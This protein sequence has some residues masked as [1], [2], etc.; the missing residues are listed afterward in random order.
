MILGLLCWLCSASASEPVVP[1]LP[2]CEVPFF[3][4]FDKV[5]VEYNWIPSRD[6]DRNGVWKVERTLVPRMSPDEFAVVTKTQSAFYGLGRRF[7]DWIQVKD[8]TL[9]LQYEVRAQTAFTCSGAYVKLFSYHKYRPH[10]LSNFTDYTIMFGPDRCADK[11]MVQFIYTHLHPVQHSYIYHALKSPPKV[12]I[13]FYTHLYTLIVRPNSTFSILID[14]VEQRNGTLFHGF[15][16]PLLEPREIVNEK[17]EKVRNP[18]YFVDLNPGA[19]HDLTGVGFEF[20]AVNQDFAF[21]NLLVAHDEKAV[22]EWNKKN[23]AVRKKY[24]MEVYQDDGDGKKNGFYRT[25]KEYGYRIRMELTEICVKYPW[26]A[27]L[28]VGCLVLYILIM[29]MWCRRGKEKTE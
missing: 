4:P 22:I 23:F 16:P 20:W 5:D 28:V 17:G 9:V 26:I 14:N 21:T 25:L 29:V 13:D 18:D 15:E 7:P 24:Q 12:P 11:N 3:E 2:D 10:L 1:R 19:W 27:V 6:D 8:R